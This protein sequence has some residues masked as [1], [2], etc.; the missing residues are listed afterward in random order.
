[1]GWELPSSAPLLQVKI[2]QC[3]THRVRKASQPHNLFPS[4]TATSFPSDFLPRCLLPALPPSQSSFC[5]QNPSA[6]M[7]QTHPSDP[8]VPR[9]V[10]PAALQ[11]S[12]F[13]LCLICLYRKPLPASTVPENIIPG[14]QQHTL[15]HSFEWFFLTSWPGSSSLCQKLLPQPPEGKAGAAASK[16]LFLPGSDSGSFIL[17]I[18][19]DFA[20]SALMC[21]SGHL[22]CANP[23]LLHSWLPWK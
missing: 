1:M 20:G 15:E 5:H 11:P 6:V 23:A 10:S 12:P 19:K 8:S 21:L 17:F 7:H 4:R 14:T 18:Q 16:N 22:A 3:Q 13:A 2:K 9:L